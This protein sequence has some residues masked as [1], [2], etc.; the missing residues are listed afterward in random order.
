[1]KKRIFNV[2]LFLCFFVGSAFVW[3]TINDKKSNSSDA[4][5]LLQR[6]SALV[7]GNDWELVKAN[8]TSLNQKI[9]KNRND[10]KSLNGL[11]ALY[12][13]EARASGQYNH[14]N[15]EAL[16]I[17]E[18]VLAI[19]PENFEA[20]TFKATILLSQHRFEDALKIAE[21]VSKKYSHNKSGKKL[22]K[23]DFE[24]S[25]V[26]F[27]A[28]FYRNFDFPKRVRGELDNGKLGWRKNNDVV[29]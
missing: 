1:M 7:Y 17:I 23:I 9:D 27:R 4:T 12:I 13:A 24:R 15:K 8:F 18:K 3:F 25:T 2:V 29:W 26:K 6:N 22:P 14:Y 5:A 28:N 21:P 16:K 20:L 10:L 11:I 19:D